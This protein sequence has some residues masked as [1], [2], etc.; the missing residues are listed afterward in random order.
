MR[1]RSLVA[2]CFILVLRPDPSVAQQFEI[3]AGIGSVCRGSEGDLCGGDSGAPL[4]AYASVLLADRFELGL[5][6]ASGR[7]DDRECNVTRDGRSEPGAPD[8]VQVFIQ[9]RSIRYPTGQAIYHFRRGKRVRPL[10]GLGAGTFTIPRTIRCEPAGCQPLLHILAGPPEAARHIDVVTI[11]GLSVQ[12][13]RHAIVRAGW[14]AHNF[15]GEE[16]SSAE[17]FLAAGWRFGR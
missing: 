14:Q 2:V 6:V 11:F 5:R 16:L 15:G 17:W 12:A 7:L 1:V 8:A 10:L 3:G 4:A 9:G 13:T